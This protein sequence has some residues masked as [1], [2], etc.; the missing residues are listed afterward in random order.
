MSSVS[1]NNQGASE[2][3]QVPAP[4]Q[5]NVVDVPA[6]GS[7]LLGFDASRLVQHYH[8]GEYTQ[9]AAQFLAV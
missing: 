5:Q 1:N 6:A 3:S 4:H 8:A 2:N 7:P 9:M